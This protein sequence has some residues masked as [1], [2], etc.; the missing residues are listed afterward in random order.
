MKTILFVATL[1]LLSACA[2]RSYMVQGGG[3]QSLC[4]TT[5]GHFNNAANGDCAM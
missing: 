1:L 3:W 2:E 5:G 4:S